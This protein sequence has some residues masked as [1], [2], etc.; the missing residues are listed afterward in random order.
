MITAKITRTK[1][2]SF[3]LTLIP[4]GTMPGEAGNALHDIYAW[5]GTQ[6]PTIAV[7]VIGKVNSTHQVTIVKQ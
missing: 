5:L 6:Q 4:G 3:Q 7:E 2:G 1:N